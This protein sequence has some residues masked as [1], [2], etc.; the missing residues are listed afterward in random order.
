MVLQYV[1][2]NHGVGEIDLALMKT[3]GVKNVKCVGIY[4]SKR[5]STSANDRAKRV[6]QWHF[7]SIPYRLPKQGT[8]V[9][10][11]FARLATYSAVDAESIIDI[12][13]EC[14]PRFFMI[15]GFFSM[16]KKQKE[17]LIEMLPTCT[18]I[19]I[20]AAVLTGH[21]RKKT[22]W[23]NWKVVY[24]KKNQF[25]ETFLVEYL[26]KQLSRDLLYRDCEITQE[27][28][29]SKRWSD[30]SQKKGKGVTPSWKNG[31]P[32][33]MLVDRRFPSMDKIIRRFDAV[34]LERLLG[35]PEKWT[36]CLTY[37]QRIEILGAVSDVS[38]IH[39][40]LAQVTT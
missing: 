35:L 18:Q 16:P 3:F 14:R 39:F 22:Y 17:Q 11:F 15:E 29:D 8:R 12:L 19:T 32:A 31:P 5:N 4:K 38:V 2:I 40:L 13:E 1:L 33:N 10:F 30:T 34:E 9:D 37:Q 36:E 28:I 23:V 25:R 26:N 21:V 20:D 27:D 24:P 7:P 6:H